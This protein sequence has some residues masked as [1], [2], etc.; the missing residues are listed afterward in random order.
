MIIVLFSSPQSLPVPVLTTLPTRLLTRVNL[1]PLTAAEATLAPANHVTNPIQC[2]SVIAKPSDYTTKSGPNYG[3]ANTTQRPGNPV[4][5]ALDV[6]DHRA[7]LQS[8]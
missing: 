3:R 6:L 2:T 1:P 8:G 7:A 5:H 4:P